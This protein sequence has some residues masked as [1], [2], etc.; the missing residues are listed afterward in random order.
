MVV[1]GRFNSFKEGAMGMLN[2]SLLQNFS[3][4]FARCRTFHFFW[5]RFCSKL[6]VIVKP[7]QYDL[8]RGPD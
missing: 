2:E 4:N 1:H 8:N 6:D 3:L 7:I 5:W